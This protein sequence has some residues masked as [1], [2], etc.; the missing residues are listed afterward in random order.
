MS[1]TELVEP[2]RI[3][4]GRRLTLESASIMKNGKRLRPAA[5]VRREYALDYSKARP[6]RFAAK[7]AGPRVVVVAR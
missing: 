7:I 5:D 6:N 2:V 1:F 3:I 4:S